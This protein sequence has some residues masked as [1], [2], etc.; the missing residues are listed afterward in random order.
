MKMHFET[1]K[2]QVY[3]CFMGKSVGGTLGMPF[4]G[5]LQ[6]HE[7]TYYD[8]VPTEMLPNDDLDL[9][10][11]NLET[12]L[13]TGL[14]VSRHHI[15]EIWLHHM[16]DSAPDEYGVAISNHKIGLRAPLSGQYRNKF[17]A[18]M[19]GAIRSELWACLAPANPALAAMLAREDACTDHTDD[20][21]Y[22]EMFLAALESAAF[23]EDDLSKLIETGLSFV[24]TESKL[25]HAF[26][27]VQRLYAETGDVMAVRSYIL[28]A[29]HSDNWTDVVI[30]LSFILLSLLASGGDFDK[31]VCT[32]VSLGY[33]ADCTGATV[34]AV[35][36]IMKPD[37]IDEKWTKPIGDGLVLSPCIINMHEW[38]TIGAFC[39]AIMSTA[40]SVQDYYRTGIEITGVM[41]LPAVRLAEKWTDDFESLYNWKV[42]D[43]ES[44]LTG[45][46]CL[47]S[48]VYPADVAG[49]PGKSKT[50]G[51][52]LTAPAALS[53]TVQLYVPEKWRV[54]PAVLSFDLTAGETATL[55][56]SV[57]PDAN[58]P[59]RGQQNILTMRFMVGG[60]SFVQ[61]AGL[62]LSCPWLVTDANGAESV[63][64]A[65]SVYFPVPAG[66]YRYR[67][68]V[69][70]TVK[71]DVHI[72]CGGTRPFTLFVN[73]APAYTSDGSFYVPAF[74]RGDSWTAVSLNRGEDNIIEVHFPDHDE[75]EFFFGFGTTL[76]C[77]TWID[78]IERML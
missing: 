8:P 41:G 17:Y 28:E 54:S 46:P 5:K 70:A 21:V 50:Y 26:R 6:T 77:G 60:L 22:A 62:P 58:L 33:D 31:A 34:G 73:G 51:L 53:G 40:L 13:R 2:K 25:Y 27:D 7:V 19:G 68:R 75:G 55:S 30:N 24:G 1:Y 69:K 52:K 67:T 37:S 64:E 29:Y 43:R 10:V 18:G 56:F 42:G 9:Q 59:R 39:D 14:P 78:S 3:G 76:Y 74:H 16:E 72:S 49:E 20:G 57:T 63:Y 11:V 71:K 47:I 66:A 15:G 44:L 36:G 48:L 4:E 61:E 32:A 65:T 35:F 45:L 38:D 23:I 12:L